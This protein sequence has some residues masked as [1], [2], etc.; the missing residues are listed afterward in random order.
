MTILTTAGLA[1]FAGAIGL[2]AVE[3]LGGEPLAE[4]RHNSRRDN[5]DQLV[6]D[7]GEAT[8]DSRLGAFRSGSSLMTR[9]A[10]QSALFRMTDRHTA[11]WVWTGLGAPDAYRIG[12]VIPDGFSAYARVEHEPASGGR[13]GRQLP[14][15]ALR[16]VFDILNVATTTPDQC[17]FCIWGAGG[18]LR[19]RTLTHPLNRLKRVTKRISNGTV[20]LVDRGKHDVAEHRLGLPRMHHVYKGKL[21]EM[22]PLHGFPWALTPDLWWPEDRAWCV[23]S[24][25]DFTWTYIGGSRSL[26]DSL[27]AHPGLRTREVRLDDPVTP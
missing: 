2:A 3:D 10:E 16:N 15:Q 22:S 4:Q 18:H 27:L 17:W 19:T 8:P 24:E 7:S 23:A 20:R 21:S 13:A 11:N 5:K 25:K 1:Y 6:R 26:V 12:S 9:P 14:E